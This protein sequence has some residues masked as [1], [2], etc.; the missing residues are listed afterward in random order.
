M[1][2]KGVIN[3]NPKAKVGWLFDDEFER[4]EEMEPA[5]LRQVRDVSLIRD[6]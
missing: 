1:I 3:F 4:T 5:F 6:F 2:Q